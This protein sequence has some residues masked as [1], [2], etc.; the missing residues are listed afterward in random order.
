V[1]GADVTRV[2]FLAQALASVVKE[3]VSA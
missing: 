3:A 1:E 2:N